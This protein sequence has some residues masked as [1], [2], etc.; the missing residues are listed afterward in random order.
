MTS[1]SALGPLLLKFS[2]V[3][4]TTLR[5][6]SAGS[7]HFVLISK[8]SNFSDL[9]VNSTQNFFNRIEMEK[10]FHISTSNPFHYLWLNDI[11]KIRYPCFQNIWTYMNHSLCKR[12]Y[13][14]SPLCLMLSSTWCTCNSSQILE[15]WC[16]GYSYSNWYWK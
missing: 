9:F 6:S 10:N 5:I 1:V 4:I 2:S 16:L 14:F 7:P 11:L 13:N 8:Q 12:K 15:A 3:S